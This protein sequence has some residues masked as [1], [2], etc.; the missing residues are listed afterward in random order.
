M[1]KLVPFLLQL[2]VHEAAEEAQV[3]SGICTVPGQ[4]EGRKAVGAAVAQPFTAVL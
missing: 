1:L 3:P 4:E 2:D